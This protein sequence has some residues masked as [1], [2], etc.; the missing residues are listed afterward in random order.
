MRRTDTSEGARNITILGRPPK[1]LFV[2]WA[3][4]LPVLQGLCDILEIPLH[5]APDFDD[6]EERSDR[7][8]AFDG[9][10]LCRRDGDTAVG[11][12]VR[13]ANALRDIPI[14]FDEL[15]AEN[16]IAVRHKPSG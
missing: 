8:A 12:L 14:V 15:E 1:Q 4:H 5:V 2:A 6:L 16:C 3:G 7:A 10:T 11:C 9:V 13:D